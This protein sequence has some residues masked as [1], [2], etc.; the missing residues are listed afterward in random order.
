MPYYTEDMDDDDDGVAPMTPEER[1]R[2]VANIGKLMARTR[3]R[4]EARERYEAQQQRRARLCRLL[5]RFEA[6]RRT[7][8]ELNIALAR[9]DLM[10]A[11]AEMRPAPRDVPNG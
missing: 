2:A 6:A 3:R 8:G 5:N 7:G 1:K 11:V 9:M 4:Q 10:G